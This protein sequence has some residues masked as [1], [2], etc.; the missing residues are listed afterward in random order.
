MTLLCTR[1]IQL[2]IDIFFYLKMLSPKESEVPFRLS[3]HYKQEKQIGKISPS[4]ANS[5]DRLWHSM[6][7]SWSFRGILSPCLLLLNANTRTMWHQFGEYT[8]L[9]S[10]P[11]YQTDSVQLLSVL[12]VEWVL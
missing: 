4:L 10:W 12:Y 9:H 6:Y 5:G 11:K 1:T 2:I 3:I 7:V 8:D